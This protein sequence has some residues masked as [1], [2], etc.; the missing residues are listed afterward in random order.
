MIILMANEKRICGSEREETRYD[1]WTGEVYDT[2]FTLVCHNPVDESDEECRG[3]CSD[4]LKE[5]S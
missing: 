4:C 1:V 5:R 3:L 2:G